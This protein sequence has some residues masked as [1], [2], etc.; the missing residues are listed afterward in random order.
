MNLMKL[1]FKSKLILATTVTTAVSLVVTSLLSYNSLQEQVNERILSN[2]DASLSREVTQLEKQVQRTIDAVT[3]VADGL[4]SGKVD[5]VPQ[6]TLMS[7]AYQVGGV[8]KM[9]VGYDDGSSYTSRPSESFPNGVGIKSKYDP[10]TRPWYS[11]AKRQSGLSLSDLFFTKNTKIPMIGVTYNL[12][13]GVIMA[14]IRFDKVR[15]ELEG[16]HYIS[17]AKAFIIDANG[18]V[19]ASTL[20]GVDAQTNVNASIVANQVDQFIANTGQFSYTNINGIDSLVVSKPIQLGNQT[21]WQMVVALNK[22]IALSDLTTASQKAT[23]TIILTILI[24]IAAIVLILNKIYQPIQSLKA[25][26]NDL[27][28]G[29]GDLTQRLEVKSDDDLG[30]IAGH[31]NQ[32]IDGLQA[33]LRDVRTATTELGNKTRIIE[34]GSKHTHNTLETHTSE[35]TQIVTAIDELS[36]SSVVVEQHSG[37]AA[38][39]ANKASEYSDETKQINSV[40]QQHIVDLEQQ[41]ASTSEDIAEMADET[42]SIQS[43]V[44][45]IG[46]IAEQTNLLALNASIEAARA[47]EHGRGFAVVADEVRALANRT[48]VS[49]SEIENALTKLQDKSERLVSS[50]EHTKRNCNDT[51]EQVDQAVSM[52]ETLD[53]QIETISGFNAEISTSSS[54]Q[55]TVIQS[56]NENIHRI[57]DLVMALNELS[58]KQVTES[59]DIM[60]LNERVEGLIGR[61]KV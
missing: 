20:E 25:L 47:G 43:I 42:Q 11:G 5:H 30:Q 60:Q 10:R 7:I 40:T 19:V 57:N 26:V 48:Q 32:F 9:F 31:I 49:T 41:I 13:N 28:R 22:S 24:S 35:T 38:Q 12:G 45:V 52:L 54:E 53:Q 4:K 34:A 3:A 15:E 2:I 8:D 33:M 29:N 17:E 50:I 1:G 27:A 58:D 56:V 21:T 18:M 51:R 44:N 61:F 59:A 39:A 14:D 6:E 46:S 37:S 55:N 36:N 23:L 16:L